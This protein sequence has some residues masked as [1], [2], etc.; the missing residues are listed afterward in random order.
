MLNEN[1][2]FICETNYLLSFFFVDNITH[3]HSKLHTIQSFDLFLKPLN[4]KRYKQTAY[5][6]HKFI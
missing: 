5:C 1:T 6:N 3:F 2:A 4:D